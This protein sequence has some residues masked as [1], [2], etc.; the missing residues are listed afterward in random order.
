[1]SKPVCKYFLN[2][3]C[4]KGSSC[5]FSHVIGVEDPS[6]RLDSRTIAQ[7]VDN[8]PVYPFS[9][10]GPE[11]KSANLISGYDWSPEELRAKYYELVSN[12]EEKQ[13]TDFEND[14]NTRIQAV[15]A[16]TKLHPDWAVR[17]MEQVK[18]GKSMQKWGPKDE[19]ISSLAK[20]APTA[21]KSPTS[22]GAFGSFG[23]SNQKFLASSSNAF[24]PFAQS[25]SA[26]SNP[27]APSA[28][29]AARSNPFAKQSSPAF[30]SSSFGSTL[31]PASNTFGS[32]SFGSTAF[33]SPAASPSSTPGAATAETTLT[34]AASTPTAFGT[35][36]FGTAPAPA[37]GST[38][39]GAAPVFGATSFGVAT[40]TATPASS[41]PAQTTT[42]S[43]GFA[44]F[45][46]AN[47]SP[48]AST[49]NSK[50]TQSPFA[51]TTS[52]NG[53]KSPFATSTASP[54]AAAAADNNKSVFGSTSTASPF[55][56]AASSN[57]AFGTKSNVSPFGAISA[58]SES[59]S[60]F[61]SKSTFLPS[62]TSSFREP[63][64]APSPFSNTGNRFA[65]LATDD[66]DEDI[67]EDITKP[68]KQ[69]APSTDLDIGGLS[70]GS[71]ATPSSTK[72]STAFG[73]RSQPSKTDGNVPD[74]PFA[75]KAF[76]EAN[77]SN[78]FAST[79]TSATIVTQTT[80]TR[81]Q[82]AAKPQ[83]QAEVEETSRVQLIEQPLPYGL[84]I[85][86]MTPLSELANDDLAAFKSSG[87]ILGKVP[88]MPPPIEL[89]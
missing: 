85:K 44:K 36:T 27:F 13:Y 61:V 28:S 57:S 59:K 11:G 72:S 53:S 74:S 47:A 26:P 2:G 84:R 4:R 40:P 50:T 25:S 71:A 58:G 80:P 45:A 7:D 88:L 83:G 1:M 70:F 51:Q 86:P 38:T 73:F 60:V 16:F 89:L 43:G 3:N 8:W 19:D 9:C 69:E 54:F 63:E 68:V 77:N 79:T 37:F 15:L 20:S 22:S 66:D 42:A 18:S 24:N 14:L 87:F 30:G 82:A 29:A 78:Q 5:K 46:P 6:D 34:P 76:G 52:S 10:Y 31:A 17:Y 62:A 21:F 39:F 48:F 64:K 67:D 33:S 35:S 65:V 49:A 12:G 55:A 41:S 32:A 23:S 81:E 75:K 56:S